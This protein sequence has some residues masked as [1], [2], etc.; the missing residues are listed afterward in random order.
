MAHDEAKQ[1]ELLTDDRRRIKTTGKKGRN[2][3][4]PNQLRFARLRKNAAKKEKT[5]T[6][7][8]P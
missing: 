7:P 2:S 8:C 6:K 4:A 3:V 1:R 5:R